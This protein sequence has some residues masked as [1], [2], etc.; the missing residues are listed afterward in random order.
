[1]LT[2]I[3]EGTFRLLGEMPRWAKIAFFFILVALMVYG[4][5]APRLVVGSVR[6]MV[7]DEK[8][9]PVRAMPIQTQIMGHTHKVT[10]N[11]EGTWAI[12]LASA[13]PKKLELLILFDEIAAIEPVKIDTMDLW[14]HDSVII[15]VEGNAVD[16]VEIASTKSDRLA[17]AVTWIASLAGMTALAGD[18]AGDDGEQ[19]PAPPVEPSPSANDVRATVVEILS[20]QAITDAENGAG[21]SDILNRQLAVEII[22]KEFS[23]PIPDEH[24]Q[25]LRTADDFAGY[26]DTRLELNQ[27]VPELQTIQ[28]PDDWAKTI[29][30]LDPSSRARVG[31]ALSPSLSG[32]ADAS[33]ETAPGIQ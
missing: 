6:A 9:K 2:A 4:L 17:D 31:K 19:K 1:M 12:P 21:T 13:F 30:T 22:E 15:Y 14:I 28:K 26:V 3:Y 25:K 24:W 29:I 27:S 10:T 20:G 5:L 32:N 18:P 16:R 7:D 8:F 11:D 23:L 33:F